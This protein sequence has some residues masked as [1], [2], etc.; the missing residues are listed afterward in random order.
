MLDEKW[1]QGKLA[2]LI[3]AKKAAEEKNDRGELAKIQKDINHNLSEQFADKYTF[4]PI[5][6]KKQPERVY[7][8]DKTCCGYRFTHEG[9]YRLHVDAEGHEE[10]VL[11]LQA[12]KE[13]ER[14]LKRELLRRD[15]LA[16]LRA[17]ISEGTTWVSSD[18]FDLLKKA[19]EHEHVMAESARKQGDIT[20]YSMPTATRRETFSDL[21]KLAGRW[22]PR[23]W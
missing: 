3:S 17:S 12:L 18:E 6:F 11:H 14:W 13:K 19:Q 9:D 1:F 15:P 5:G 10:R 7:E 4:E 2:E 21:N 22:E 16:R 8:F 20:R 23:N